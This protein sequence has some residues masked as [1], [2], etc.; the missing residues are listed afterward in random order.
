MPLEATLFARRLRP[1]FAASC[2]AVALTVLA[3][4]PAFAGM[5]VSG[6]KAA[7]PL[8]DN[9]PVDS[10]SPLL[11]QTEPPP[12]VGEPEEPAKTE[13]P[14]LFPEGSAKPSASENLAINLIKK[15]VERGVLPQEDA[16]ELIREAEA[17]T[18]AARQ[19]AAAE[20]Q[21][22]VDTAV[23]RAVATVQASGAAAMIDPLFES[24]DAVRVTYIPETVKAQLRDELRA[25]VLTQAKEERWADPR[26]VPG[27]VS[28]I[29][30]FGDV[31]VRGEG[32]MFPNGNDNTGAFPNFN[33]INTGAPFDLS[34][35][36]FSA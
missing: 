25:E 7:L 31:R 1:A 8:P 17:E 2:S 20:Q 34:G 33:S 12:L 27:W 15:L 24:E 11:A 18:A 9:Q 10:A 29:R 36:Q 21:A 30:L 3:Q 28:R 16:D 4:T 23:A 26:L 32:D 13:T 35:R 22:V 14:G 5:P 6:E 19:Q